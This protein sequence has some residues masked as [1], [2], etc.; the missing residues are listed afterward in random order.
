MLCNAN[1]IRSG[2]A[3]GRA[4]CFGMTTALRVRRCL[5]EL[6]C[7]ADERRVLTGGRL[8]LVSR[9]QPELAMGN[10]RCAALEALV[11][12]LL[13]RLVSSQPDVMR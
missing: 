2:T 13:G 5:A 1:E 12:W 4:S 11:R 8:G 6:L 3:S 10:A 7:S 9:A